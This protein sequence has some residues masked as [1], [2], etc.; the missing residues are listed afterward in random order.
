MEWAFIA[1]FGA[2]GF[3]W[4]LKKDTSAGAVTDAGSHICLEC[5]ETVIPGRKTRG[6]SLI[7]VILWLFMILPG[8][9]YSAWRRSDKTGWCPS[10]GSKRLVP[11]NSPAGRKMANR[12]GQE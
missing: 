8:V 2:I 5:G 12:S 4:A 11:I 7:E 6:S 10:C 9:I 3:W 1:L